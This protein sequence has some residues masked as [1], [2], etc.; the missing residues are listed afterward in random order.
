MKSAADLLN[1]F[2]HS[3]TG[4]FRSFNI[5]YEAGTIVCSFWSHFRQDSRRSCG[6]TPPGSKQV[7]QGF[8][9]RSVSVPG[10]ATREQGRVR[11]IHGDARTATRDHDHC[12]IGL[13]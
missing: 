3:L 8:P 10:V 9:T 1:R 11:L 5:A 4:A 12:L 7:R 6:T 2:P 13:L